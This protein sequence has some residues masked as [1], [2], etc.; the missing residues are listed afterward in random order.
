MSDSDRILL[1]E[2][3]SD[4][5]VL[6]QRAFR[7]AGVRTTLAVVDD[8]DSAVGYLEGSGPWADRSRHPLPRLVLLDLKLPRRSGLEVLAWLRAQPSLLGL[9]VVVLTSSREN[10]DLRRA[11]ELGANSFLVK[12]V[13]F[14][15]LLDLV[16]TLDLYWM[17]LNQAPSTEG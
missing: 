12:P 15:D 17:R 1:V 13:N 10:T 11:Y 7:R 2:D 5:V 14:D 9:T 6:I 16:R 4:D 3:N 8:G